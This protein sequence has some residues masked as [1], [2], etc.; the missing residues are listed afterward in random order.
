MA[1]EVAEVEHLRILDEERPLLG[2]ERLEGGQV[3]HRRVHF[4]LAEIGIER[5]VK[6]EVRGHAVAQVQA[7]VG[8]RRALRV[9][10]RPTERRDG[11]RLHHRV[12]HELERLP[13]RR[14]LEAN[15]V[16][17]P[18]GPACVVLVPE[19]PI[20]LLVAALDEATHL[21]SPRLFCGARKA[22]LAVGNPDLRGP[23]RGIDARGCF[24]D[25]IPGLIA[26]RRPDADVVA[27]RAGGIHL[28]ERPAQVVVIAIDDDLEI[29]GVEA[30][31]SAYEPRQ[32]A[33]R[34][35]GVEH[36]R[37]H[38]QRAVVK[39]ESH[40]GALRG[41]LSL[42]GVGLRELG[43]RRRRLPRVLVEVPVQGHG[44]APRDRHGRRDGN[45]VAIA[46]VRARGAL[47]A[48]V[49][50]AARDRDEGPR[51]GHVHPRSTPAG[52]IALGSVSGRLDARLGGT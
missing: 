13:R 27:L 31:V 6:R 51:P 11:R 23:S 29:V 10:R 25:Q 30:R 38:V 12:R 19:R 15:Q 34:A 4:H 44:T 22:Q 46:G 50:R 39:E 1:T 9:E 7:C 24:P 40:L 47:R 8:L 2:E 17:E 14:N 18:R 37:A 52:C 28:E 49:G 5:R 45:R 32:D 20:V 21:Q 42:L 36:P 41:R 3:Q 48:Q 26:A 16:P 33:A 35:R 43:D